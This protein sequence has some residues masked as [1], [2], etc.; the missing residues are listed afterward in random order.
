MLISNPR[1]SFLDT[2]VVH[3]VY[4]LV[5]YKLI[6]DFGRYRNPEGILNLSRTIIL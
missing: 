3:A 2:V 6:S 5:K 4:D 1:A